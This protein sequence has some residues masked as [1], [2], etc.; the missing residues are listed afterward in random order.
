MVRVRFRDG[1]Q[2]SFGEIVLEPEECNP[3]NFEV[4]LTGGAQ[5]HWS[6]IIA[7]NFPNNV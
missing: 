2:F 7:S 3:S 5:F 1:G 4:N 6:F